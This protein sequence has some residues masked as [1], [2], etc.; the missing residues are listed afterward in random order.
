MIEPIRSQRF[1]AASRAHFAWRRQIH[2]KSA[3][4]KGQTCIRDLRIK[5]MDLKYERHYAVVLAVVAM[6]IP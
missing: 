3:M 2:P 6:F 5:M 1:D 4:E